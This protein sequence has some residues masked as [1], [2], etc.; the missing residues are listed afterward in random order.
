MSSDVDRPREG[1][2]DPVDMEAQLRHLWSATVL[3]MLGRPATPLADHIA[4]ESGPTTINNPYWSIVRWLPQSSWSTSDTLTPTVEGWMTQRFPVNRD[5]LVYTYSFAIPSPGDIAFL[6]RRIGGR[7]VIELGAGTGYWA[8]QLTQ[9]GVDLI[10]YDNYEWIN[11][12]RL[13]PVPFHPVHHGSIETIAEHPDR[14]LMLCW[15]D[16]N[17]PFAL[18]ALTAYT[19]DG[20]IYIG[21]GW[22]G[23][24]GDDEFGRTL[25]E[26]WEL[27]ASSAHHV[28]FAG[29]HS[30]IGL[31]RRVRP[32]RALNP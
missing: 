4:G 10:A 11:Q 15:P 2:A 19:G 12:G 7:G 9:A 29:I 21:E 1:I 8:W 13:N 23:C 5:M 16:Y 30:D 3:D 26:E 6:A 22:G 14:L 27:T 25:D 31:Y 20:L 24:T 17:T 18:D 28:N 32:L